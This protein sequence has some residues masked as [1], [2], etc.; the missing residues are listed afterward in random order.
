MKTKDFSLLTSPGF[1]HVSPLFLL[2][3]VLILPLLRTE[4]AFSQNEKKEAFERKKFEKKILADPSTGEIPGYI[5]DKEMTFA[6]TLP[7][8]G[9]AGRA[10]SLQWKQRG[11]WN[12]G[13]I[14]R[15][16]ARDISNPQIMMAGSNSGGLYRSTDAGNSWTI[17]TPKSEFHG[18]TTITQDKRPGKTSTWY[19]GSGDPYS[20]ASAAEAFYTGR[21]VY[22]STDNGLTWT[23]LS[24]TFSSTYIFDSQ[25]EVIY[26]VLTDHTDSADVVYAACYGAIFKSVNG[27]TSWTVA[28]GNT[29][30]AQSFFTH[31]D[32]SPSGVLYATLDSDGS[33]KGIWRSSDGNNWTNIMPPNFPT[34]YN[35]IVTGIAPSNE[36]VVYFLGNTP[37]F[38]T[39][40]TNF[41]GDVEWNSLWKYTYISGNGDGAG[42]VWEDLSG[43]LPTN[44]GQF[45]KYDSQGSYNMIVAVKPDDEN[46]VIIGGTNIFRSTNG[47]ADA[48]TNRF[49]GGYKEGTSFPRFELY[50]KHHPDQHELF[51]DSSNPSVL[52]NGCDGGVYRTDNCMADTVEW[53]ELNKGYITTQW[54]TVTL[55]HGTSGDE[56]IFCG[57]QDNGNWF[58]NNSNVQAPWTSVRAG[59]GAYCAIADGGNPYY[60]SIQNGRMWKANLDGNG[61]TLSYGRIDPIGGERYEFINPFVIDPNDN[62]LMYLA[63]GKYLWRNDDLSSIPTNNTE[64]S[65]STNWVQWPDSVPISN[66]VITSVAVSDQNPSNRVIYGT[67]NQRVY[68]VDNANSGTP[69]AQN[70]TGT[71]NP[72]I[73][74]LNGNVVCVTM[75]P[76]DA[77]RIFVVF[78]NYGVYSLFYSENGGTSWTKGAGNLEANN[79]GT[80]NGPSLRWLTVAHPPSGGTIYL[81]GTSIG[82][83][84]TGKLN[85]TSTI[86]SQIGTDEIGRVVVSM[87]DYRRSDGMLVVSTQGAGIFSTMIPDT[88]SVFAG[89]ASQRPLEKSMSAVVNPNPFD[90]RVTIIINSLMEQT[91]TWYITDDRGR[92]VTLPEKKKL[93]T[94]KN[95]IEPDTRLWPSGA[96][97]FHIETAVQKSSTTMLKINQ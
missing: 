94:G 13:G 83:F 32:I 76:D 58:T 91:A 61:N 45:D 69:L 26:R 47:F 41:V 74:P 84:A 15:A 27:G 90:S 34:T 7:N 40:D 16:F 38:G 24:S 75:D 12:V 80:G 46:T 6:R 2:L 9:G 8:D 20:S 86:W 71:T 55:D 23:V 85:G 43:S 28:R 25:W 92:F 54:Y 30:G 3:L 63:G 17:V 19:H 96:Y 64:D 39:P 44:G 35:R 97:Y 11:P 29:S 60:L 18:I 4:Q 88:A 5:R 79:N 73:F 93:L 49:I 59:D 56:K 62:N 36:N 37:G 89:M 95:L 78:S 70:I 52:Y 42:G 51:F 67:N 57:S 68:K 81:L 50:E 22:K 1:S 77:D 82:L 31:I 65:I 53:E 72:A 14:T 48:S 66:G 87:M 33:G 21:G 10:S